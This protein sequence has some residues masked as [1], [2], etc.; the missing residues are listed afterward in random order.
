MVEKQPLRP[1]ETKEPIA[2]RMKTQQMSI[3]LILDNLQLIISKY[4]IQTRKIPWIAVNL[5]N[6]LSSIVWIFDQKIYPHIVHILG[7]KTQ[8]SELLLY[9][10]A[11]GLDLYA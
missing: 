8:S 4:K 2:C 5:L 7:H 10:M 11:H 3:T 6:L 1:G 9:F